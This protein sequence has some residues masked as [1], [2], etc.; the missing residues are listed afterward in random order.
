MELANFV[1]EIRSASFVNSRDR[2]IS[3]PPALTVLSYYCLVIS[4][5][6]LARH[7]RT[8]SIQSCRHPRN[9]SPA[10]LSYLPLIFPCII[11]SIV[12]LKSGRL[13]CISGIRLSKLDCVTVYILGNGDVGAS[14]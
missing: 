1:A 10:I 8:A 7:H 13:H 4:A 12:E 2:H 9:P 11:I 5:K 3:Q 6:I 14:F